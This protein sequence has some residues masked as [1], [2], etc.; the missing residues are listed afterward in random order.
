[1]KRILFSSAAAIAVV[2]GLSSFKEA[3]RVNTYYF[4]V[5]VSE[6][7]PT[8]GALSDIQVTRRTAFTTNPGDI[9]ATG[10]T[11][12]CIVGF[13]TSQLTQTNKVH[14]NTGTGGSAAPILPNVTI[15][16]RN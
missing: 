5:K 4:D 11:K 2:V 9:C 13:L 12:L 3:K 16:T 8:G 7:V 1:M 15:S 6:S 14:L 10:A